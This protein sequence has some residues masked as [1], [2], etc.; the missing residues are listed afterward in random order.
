MGT[1]TS[2]PSDKAARIRSADPLI[3]GIAEDA[4]LAAMPKIKTGT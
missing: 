1:T 2:D 3:S 4:R